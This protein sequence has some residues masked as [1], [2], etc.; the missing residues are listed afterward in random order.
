[1][2]SKG[3]DAVVSRYEEAGADGMLVQKQVE[4]WCFG[5]KLVWAN[6]RG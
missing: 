3:G 6:Q 5:I 1:M 2:R 4:A